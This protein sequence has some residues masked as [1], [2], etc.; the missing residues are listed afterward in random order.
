MSEVS[1]FVRD[2]ERVR[3]PFSQ[4]QLMKLHQ[5]GQLARFH[6]ISTDRKNWVKAATLLDP[7]AREPHPADP[8]P[9]PS[10][11]SPSQEVPTAQATTPEQWPQAPEVTLAGDRPRA[12][13]PRSRWA[14]AVAAPCVLISIG[15][16]FLALRDA[17]SVLPTSFA[18]GSAI[19][20]L[21]DDDKVA[22]AVGLVVVGIEQRMPDGT[23][24]DIPISTGTCFVV[25]EDGTL[26]TNRHV[27]E[28][29][30]QMSNA[31][32]IDQRK[33]VYVKKLLENDQTV[34]RGLEKV[35]AD[36]RGERREEI[37]K[38]LSAGLKYSKFDPKIW[39][40]LMGKNNRPDKYVAE[41]EYL[42]DKTEFDIAIL[43]IKR[44]AGDTGRFP[45]FRISENE[46]APK[47]GD[48]VVA[49]GFPGVTRDA[50]SVEEGA[51][52]RLRKARAS[53]VE[54]LF[55]DR[56]FLY[57]RTEGKVTQIFSDKASGCR[58]IQHNADITHGN[59]GGPLVAPQGL[60]V[61]V[62]TRGDND[63]ATYRAISAPQLKGILEKYASGASFST[64]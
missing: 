9:S 41:V 50:V 42:C 12:K 39:V 19:Q 53:R 22:G 52:E 24:G 28:F 54:S 60:V 16:M 8:Q 13:T 34:E 59:S 57:V 36:K 62:N 49:L 64:R 31:Q 32:D 46:K 26:V 7:I 5:R 61:G 29:H 45:A 47:K 44:A 37:M 1:W 14:I 4:E 63:G 43:K 48:T 23:H 3:G 21:E 6:D 11:P 27:V 20:S 10:R 40:F 30:D 18:E 17:K 15:L 58:W 51:E 25:S 55:K 56:D 35:P 38:T 33:L 2:K